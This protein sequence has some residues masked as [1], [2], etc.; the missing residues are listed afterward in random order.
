MDALIYSI[1]AGLHMANVT[2]WIAHSAYEIQT[3]LWLQ[4]L[5]NRDGCRYSTD[6]ICYSFRVPSVPRPH[7]VWFRDE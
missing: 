4:W 7:R 5:S 3:L 2:G 1:L 6:D